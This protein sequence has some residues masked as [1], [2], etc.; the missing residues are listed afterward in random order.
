[1]RLLSFMITLFNLHI[2]TT[3]QVYRVDFIQISLIHVGD[4]KAVFFPRSLFG[5][6][7]LGIWYYME[8]FFISFCLNPWREE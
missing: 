4:S 1:M 8:I 2:S 5:L 7:K 6:R 3:S